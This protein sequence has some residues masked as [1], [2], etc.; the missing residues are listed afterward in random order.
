M[1]SNITSFSTPNTIRFEDG[2]VMT[3]VAVRARWV[4]NPQSNVLAVVV[5]GETWIMV[6]GKVTYP[7]TG[8]TVYSDFVSCTAAVRCPQN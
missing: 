8:A 6:F 5:S 7:S 3:D 1:L 2:S 4:N